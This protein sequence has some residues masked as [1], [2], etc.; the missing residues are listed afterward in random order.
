MNPMNVLLIE[1]DPLVMLGAQQALQLADMAVAQATTAEA[2]MQLVKQSCPAAILTDVRLPGKDGFELLQQVLALD[3]EVPVILMTGHGDIRM[4]VQAMH[5]GAYDF[6]EKPFSSERLVEVMRRALEKRRLVLENRRLQALV[7]SPQTFG[8]IGETAGMV[9]V[10]RRIAA[11]APTQVD[12]LVRG[13]TGTGKEVVARAI[14]EASGRTGPFVAI[15]CGALP[16]AIFES[17]MFGHEAGAFTG[18][19]R[20]RVGKLEYACGGTVFLDEIE[21][22][23]MT[24][25]VKLLRVLQEKAMERLGGNQ[26]LQIDCRFIAAA[27]ADLKALSDTGEFRSDLYY[28]LHVACVELAPLRERREDIPQ[29]MAHCLRLSAERYKTAAPPISATQV[30]QWMAHNWP[31]NVREL[32]NV[33]DRLCLGLEPD[34]NSIERPGD[35]EP[36]LGQQMDRFEKQLLSDALSGCQGNVAQAATQLKVPR[37]TLYDKITRHQ[38]DPAMYR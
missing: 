13:E 24:Q 8:L 20:K 7:A 22:L 26:T 28:R 1:D 33:A 19:A 36:S 14:H 18:A 38:I 29:L 16:E 35:A 25:Q 10:R 6:L 9:E 3:S 32:K 17:E 4:A 31:G 12:V 30:A 15:N 27:K 21:S 34:E 23:P 11:L 2:A 37:K 5:L